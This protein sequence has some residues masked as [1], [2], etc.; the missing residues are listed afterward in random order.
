[1]PS[2]STSDMTKPK[3]ERLDKLLVERGLVET[4]AK[5]QA[6][7]LAGQVFSDLQRL[8][9]AGQLVA[10]D[11]PLTI[12]ETMPYVSRGGFKLAAAL[13]QFAV[14]VTD[15]VCLDIGASTGGF[16]D[17]LLQRGA[18]RITALD[19]GH[20][21]LDWR[22]RNDPRVT[23]REHVN[24][25]YLK[26]EDF[27]ERFALVVMD[28]SFISL[29]KILPALPALLADE[30]VVI[31]LVKPQF[32]VGRDE[33]GKGGIVRDA[34]AQQRVVQEICACAESLNWQTRGVMDSPILGM[35]GN[36]EFL[37]RFVT[38]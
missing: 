11:A 1:M 37:A 25:R 27:A 21:Q 29:T 20:G 30:A 35:D 14:D 9:K 5:A 10:I 23:V 24:A 2:C 19:V 38:A 3:K 13:D 4:R 22:L 28:V 16:T 12:K 36:K 17:C 18:A 6:L 34:A 8:D 26:P 31:T 33:V 32:E 7:I 15:K